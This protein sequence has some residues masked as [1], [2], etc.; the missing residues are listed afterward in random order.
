LI[1]E[2]ERKDMPAPAF[3]VWGFWATFGFGLWV[4]AMNMLCELVVI[5]AFIAQQALSGITIDLEFIKGFQNNG[6]LV[7][8]ATIVAAP[9]CVGLIVF[10]IKLKNGSNLLGYLGMRPV[11]WQTI[12]ISLGILLVFEVL[13]QSLSNFIN[14]KGTSFT[15][16]VFKTAGS[17][18]LLWL[19]TV[20]FAP[21]FEEV[22]FRGFLFEGF[23]RSPVGI[24][25]ALFLTSVFWAVLH[26]QYDLFAIGSIFVLGIIIGLVRW[27]TGSIWSSLAMHMFFN[28]ISMVAVTVQVTG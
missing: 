11:R 8:M 21:V 3:P 1:T 13:L 18:P 25:G 12:L 28:L 9:V 22:L 5:V 2:E 7:S 26:M 17:V 15:E 20:I 6:L 19:A 16:D 23:R 10:I 24:V 4:M 14:Y 27:R